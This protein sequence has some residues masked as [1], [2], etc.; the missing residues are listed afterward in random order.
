[1]AYYLVEPILLSC[2]RSGVTK[3]KF[4]VLPTGKEG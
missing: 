1:V 3:V 2:A 4:A